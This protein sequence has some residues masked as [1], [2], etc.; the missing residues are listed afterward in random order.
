MLDGFERR[1]ARSLAGVAAASEMLAARLDHPLRS[2]YLQAEQA[3]RAR[4]G[5]SGA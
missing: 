3:T 2:R 4:A 1:G 5:T